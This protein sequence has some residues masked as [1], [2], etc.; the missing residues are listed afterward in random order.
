MTQS[1]IKY[2]LLIPG[3]LLIFIF[4]LTIKNSNKQY[5]QLSEYEKIETC[6]EMENRFASDLKNGE[7]KYFQFGIGRDIWLQEILESKY[8]I[9]C[10]GMGCSIQSE[11]ECYNNMVENYL[12]QKYN[13]TIADIIS[14]NSIPFEIPE[15]EISKNIFLK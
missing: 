1:K 10:L 13:K 11:I 8:K 9:E 14:E 7:I 3:L 2:S 5:N 12:K 6:D 15:E 4:R